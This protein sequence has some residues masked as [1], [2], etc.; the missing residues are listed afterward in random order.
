MPFAIAISSKE[1]G[2]I[3]KTLAILIFLTGSIAQAKPYDFKFKMKSEVY[4]YSTAADSYESAFEKA[5]QACFNHFKGG[6]R[7]SQDVGLDII[8][9]CANPK[10]KL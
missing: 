3:M 8:D 4:E 7:V 6:R 1:T 2:V 5:A 9:V 10:N